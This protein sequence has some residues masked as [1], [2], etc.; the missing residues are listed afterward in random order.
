[1]ARN[2]VSELVHDTCEAIISELMSDVLH[3]PTTPEEW[4][5]V[6]EQFFH[7]WDLHHTVGALDGKHIAIRCPPGGGS[8]YYNYKGFHSIVLL[9]L[10]DSNYK[11]LYVDVGSP[12][13][14][15][16]GGIFYNTPIRR[17]LESN[18]LGL[19]ASEPL[20]DSD[21]PVPYFFVADDAFPLRTW[22]MKPYNFRGLSQQQRTFNYRVSRARRVVENAF[23]ILA[24]R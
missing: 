18:T 23:G 15:S 9:A 12:G 22:L 7:R 11:F 14:G 6:A 3:C 2:T 10:V 21:E 20:P 1:M 19:P 13:S 5:Q 8:T 4:K 24:S 17:A 16:D